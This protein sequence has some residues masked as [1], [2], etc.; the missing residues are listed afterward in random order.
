[1]W[2]QAS[3]PTSPSIPSFAR[4]AAVNLKRYPAVNLVEQKQVSWGVVELCGQSGRSLTGVYAH[5]HTTFAF[6]GDQA[7]T[8]PN[9]HSSPTAP[10][11][12]GTEK[13]T[14]TFPLAGFPP[15]AW[16]RKVGRVPW[17]GAL[18]SWEVGLDLGK[19]LTCQLLVSLGSASPAP[20]AGMQFSC[21]CWLPASGGE[22]RALL[23]GLHSPR[24]QGRSWAGGAS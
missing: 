15:N 22:P 13:S 17:K 1:M 9:I 3:Y 12:S 16:Q 2:L 18:I 11:F 20:Y 5:K 19:I 10:V 8:H 14:A 23:R 24:S 4:G 7:E 6:C 21:R